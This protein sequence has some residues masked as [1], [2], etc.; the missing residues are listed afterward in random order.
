MGK[1]QKIVATLVLGLAL[2][3]T[4]AYINIQVAR[5]DSLLQSVN[6]YEAI[7]VLKSLSLQMIESG[8]IDFQSIGSI[9]EK[10]GEIYFLN[11]FMLPKSVNASG[12]FLKASASV[13]NVINPK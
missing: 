3:Q 12:N 2:T 8:Q 4:D 1:A 7:E 11:S 9:Y 5:S 13:N 10:I 6:A